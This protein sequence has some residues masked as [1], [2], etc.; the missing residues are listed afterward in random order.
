M[1]ITSSWKTTLEKGVP[2]DHERA[3]TTGSIDITNI[4][5]RHGGN[6]GLDDEEDAGGEEDD[7]PDILKARREFSS[8]CVLQ[9]LISKKLTTH[10]VSS[11]RHGISADYAWCLK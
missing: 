6:G 9:R 1:E 7:D 8:C 2:V 4:V 3:P 10:S 11:P 5:R